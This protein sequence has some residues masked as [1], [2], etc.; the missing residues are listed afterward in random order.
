MD[1]HIVDVAVRLRHLRNGDMHWSDS[2]VHFLPFVG[3]SLNQV[4]KLVDI[5]RYCR[6][7]VDPN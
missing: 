5:D 7:A 3:N 1:K 2:N 6:P 4:D